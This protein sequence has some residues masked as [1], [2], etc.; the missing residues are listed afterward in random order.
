MK[1]FLIAKPE[2]IKSGLNTDAYFLRTEE[3]LEGMGKN[4]DVV[5]EL[6]TKSFPD[7]NYQFG[8]VLGIYEV[9]KL[10]EGL[11]VDV[12]AMDEGEI[13]FPYEP[14]LQIRGKYKD[15][16]RYETTILGF[17]SFM[18]G[19]GTKSA[20]VR[21]AAKDKKIY[22]FGTR[23]QHPFLSPVVEYC[24]YV[25]GF[26][27]VSNV[28]GAKYIFKTPVGTMPHA[29][30]LI[31]GDEKEAFLAFDQYVD[32]KVPR[33]ALVDTYGSPTIGAINALEALK[34]KLSGVRIDSKDY[35]YL[36]KDIKWEFVRRGFSN[37]QIFLS[38]GLDEYEVERFYD[39]ADAFGVGTRVANAPVIDFALKIVEVD[40]NPVAKV[41]NMP[42]AKQVHRGN[43]YS[44]TI[45]LFNSELL[46]G[47]RPLL[48]PLIREGQIVRD[49]EEIDSIRKRVLNNINSLP[50]NL[51]LIKGGKT[52]IPEFLP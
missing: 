4:P 13:F 40:G 38:G 18:S 45:R 39:Y 48:K 17:I 46:P 25:S 37:V 35:A 8:V 15:F 16:A 11:P 27:G 24:T 3:V 23:R 43:G 34:E 26:D 1:E 50:E 42:G 44:D 49:F 22:S 47:K 28:L 12:Y 7:E 30:I 5:M 36:I 31:I 29:L 52:Y 2:E 19:I 20:R 21:I 14:V 6:F 9:A 33:I 10:L 51:K 41:G 32:P